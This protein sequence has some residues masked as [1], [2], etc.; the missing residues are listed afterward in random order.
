V[1][2]LADEGTPAHASVDEAG[3]R[4]EYDALCD[5]ERLVETARP[6]VDLSS[7]R[8]ADVLRLRAVMLRRLGLADLEAMRAPHRAAAE[9]LHRLGYL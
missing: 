7:E 9:E 2:A 5:R 4:Y 1:E 3:L 6:D 8:P